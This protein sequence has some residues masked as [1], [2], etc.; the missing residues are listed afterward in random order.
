MTTRA[1]LSVVSASWI[2]N[3]EAAKDLPSMETSA[4][5]DN[6]PE[7]LCMQVFHSKRNDEYHARIV[8]V[9]HFNTVDELTEKW[10]KIK[11][12]YTWWAVPMDP[13][14]SI[15][16]VLNHHEHIHEVWDHKLVATYD[17]RQRYKWPSR[18]VYTRPYTPAVPTRVFAGIDDDG[19]PFT[20]GAAASSLS[21]L[22]R[23]KTDAT[24]KVYVSD[25]ESDS[26]SE[27]DDAA[28]GVAY[29]GMLLRKTRCWKCKSVIIWRGEEKGV[30][31]LC[32][33]CKLVGEP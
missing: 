23:A 16:S 22:K 5:N 1:F 32:R 17:N 8:V 27:D 18:E 24:Q 29:P 11:N 14:E 30:Y 26:S 13:K 33:A 12:T 4:M 9:T 15:E 6:A 25:S 7:M 21:D 28:P 31:P 3:K 2:D 20:M 19:E 10:L